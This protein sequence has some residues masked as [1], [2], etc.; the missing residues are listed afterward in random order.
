[1]W[2]G[3]S[4]VRLNDKGTHRKHGSWGGGQWIQGQVTMGT[5]ALVSV[6]PRNGEAS[7]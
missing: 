5:K 4:C 3:S 7:E 1:M 6:R 2:G